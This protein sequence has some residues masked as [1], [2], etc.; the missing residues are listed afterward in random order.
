M[1][2]ANEKLLEQQ[3]FM[4][5][6]NIPQLLTDRAK[7]L[8]QHLNKRGVKVSYMSEEDREKHS[9]LG[10]SYMIQGETTPSF[11]YITED[12]MRM[13][14]IVVFPHGT[15]DAYKKAIFKWNGLSVDSYISNDFNDRLLDDE[16]VIAMFAHFFQSTMR[17][18]ERTTFLHAFND[19]IT[20]RAA[21]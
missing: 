18:D 3:L 15:P 4:L 6:K 14:V 19:L 13:L 1:E 12:E 8:C 17:G 20:S 5:L 7:E 16:S 10:E 9:V 21:A 11:T 2:H